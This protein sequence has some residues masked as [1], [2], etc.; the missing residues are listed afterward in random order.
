MWY[1]PYTPQLLFCLLLSWLEWAWPCF[2]SSFSSPQLF[3]SFFLL[4]ELGYK[5]LFLV[6]SCFQQAP[7]LLHSKNSLYIEALEGKRKIRSDC[8]HHFINILK[9][10]KKEEMKQSPASGTVA[11]DIITRHSLETTALEARRKLHNC[12]W[13]GRQLSEHSGRL[14]M[15][16]EKWHLI[17][18][19]LKPS[20][21]QPPGMQVA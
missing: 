3:L 8:F 10:K 15:W 5:W 17:K 19:C 6:F 14:E 1:P 9:F 18:T 12:Q 11:G 21:S 2:P 7:T 13:R 20:L 4:E 16:P